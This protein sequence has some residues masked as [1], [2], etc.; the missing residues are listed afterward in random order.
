MYL[1]KINKKKT[2]LITVVIMSDNT[3]ITATY[4]YI[5]FTTNIE[6]TII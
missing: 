2:N 1:Q 6:N 5:I 4:I 3:R